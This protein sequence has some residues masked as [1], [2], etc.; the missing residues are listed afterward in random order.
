MLLFLPLL[1]RTAFVLDK[2]LTQLC[3]LV[4][5]G[6]YD[7]NDHTNGVSATPIVA[8]SKEEMSAAT[9]T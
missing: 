4:W 2:V 5:M 7:D 8:Q 3:A 1:L 9:S 6:E